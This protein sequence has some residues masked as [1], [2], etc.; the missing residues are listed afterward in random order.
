MP[1]GIGVKEAIVKYPM[2]LSAAADGT[3]EG[4]ELAKR[5]KHLWTEYATLSARYLALMKHL[6]K[7][8]LTADDVAERYES[9]ERAFDELE[10]RQNALYRDLEWHC[11]RSQRHD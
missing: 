1:V 4:A 6:P 7:L 2:A 10:L 8:R 11:G 3:Q 5:W 9:V